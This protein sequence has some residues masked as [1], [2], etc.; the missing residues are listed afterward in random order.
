[1]NKNTLCWLIF[2]VAIGLLVASFVYMSWVIAILAAVM[3]CL[4]GIVGSQVDQAKE[5]GK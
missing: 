2:S 3:G 1:M 4:L 5:Q